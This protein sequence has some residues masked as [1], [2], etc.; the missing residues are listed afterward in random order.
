MTATITAT[1][2]V[3]TSLVEQVLRPCDGQVRG[4]FLGLVVRE[5]SGLVL[6]APV[7]PLPAWG[8]LVK[9]ERLGPGS[10]CAKA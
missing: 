10:V 8:S 6:R 5:D 1:A 2:A 7:V 9:S 3:T 4:T